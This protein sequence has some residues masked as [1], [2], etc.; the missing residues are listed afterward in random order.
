MTGSIIVG[1]ADNRLNAPGAAANT[2]KNGGGEG[3]DK[4]MNQ[5]T[6]KPDSSPQ[7]DQAAAG[8]AGRKP[9]DAIV[10]TKGPKDN[11]S[12]DQAADKKYPSAAEGADNTLGTTD[13][14]AGLGEGVIDA[15]AD[16]IAAIKKEIMDTFEIS[17]EQL[18][19]ALEQLG[20]SMTD[21]F[22]PQSI[23]DLSVE[24]TGS[25]DK[26]ALITNE[27]LYAD[28]KSLL[29]TVQD[30]SGQLMNELG[31]EEGQLKE[32]LQTVQEQDADGA[33]I[34]KPDVDPDDVQAEKPQ[35]TQTEQYRTP[36]VAARPETAA[37]MEQTVK[38]ADQA[39]KPAEQALTEQ[40]GAETKAHSEKTA[41]A[42]ELKQ[43]SGQSGAQAESGK[44]ETQTMMGQEQA[45][46]PVTDYVRAQ[47]EAAVKSTYSE[48]QVD[49]ESIMK[50][51]EA[52]MKLNLRPGISEISMQLHPESLG[53]IHL[54]VI[55]KNGVVTAQLAA[56]TEAVRAAIE[57]QVAVLKDS[58]NEQGL[59]VEA[60]EVTV[61]SHEFDRN[62]EQGSGEQAREE[63]KKSAKAARRISLE[64]G[65]LDA[66]E[67]EMSD[68]DK[69]A[70]DMMSRS[71]NSVDYIA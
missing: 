46:N 32:L 68:A 37:A 14:T 43:D 60:V 4:V 3:F 22:D 40:Q 18:M 38:T 36:V 12:V 30:V 16:A 67:E 19:A 61:A 39:A 7:K 51:V 35:D 1:A 69:M 66:M 62:L 53:S 42:P 20:M 48:S 63:Q 11:P 70:A 54:Q 41:E 47:V 29:Q 13:E 59:K 33:D 50:Q 71:G 6:Q 21:L 31:L 5:M 55:A 52:Q 44:G 49:T 17:E 10:D 57:S 2:K 56:E 45:G 28:V 8:N 64:L 65:G 23:I 9:A 27:A 15:V 34:P 25:G 26:M 24:L 58:M